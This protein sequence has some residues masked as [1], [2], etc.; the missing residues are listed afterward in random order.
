MTTTDRSSLWMWYL[1]PALTMSLGWG[2]RG[3]IGGG[4]L[5]AM[6]PGAMIGLALCY[7]LGR[8]RDAAFIA[9]FAAVGVGFGG[10]ET[11]GQTVGL[12]L[13]SETFVWAITGF[14]LKGAIWGFLG[15]AVLGIAFTIDRYARRDVVAGFACMIA[16]TFAGWKLINE[17]KLIYFSNRLDRPRAEIWAG[18]LLGALLLLLWMGWR[19]GARL[20][21]RFALWG[22]LGGGVGF[23][24]GAALQVWGRWNGLPM[25]VGWWKIMEFTFGALLGLAYGHCASVHRGELAA[26]SLPERRPAVPASLAAAIVA[27]A[28]ALVLSQGLKVRFPQTIAG[29]LLLSAAL[30]WDV[31]ARHIAVTVTYCAYAIDLQRNRL[32]YPPALMWVFIVITTIAVAVFMTRSPRVRSAFLLLT[33]SAVAMALLKTFLPPWGRGEAVGTQCA[34]VALALAVIA[35]LLRFDGSRRQTGVAVGTGSFERAR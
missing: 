6:I 24:S 18:L 23:A 31:L 14:A 22:A 19:G 3:F 17:P 7:L 11:Y 28:I 9:A 8:E 12:S 4:F 15:G 25:P 21:W 2:L 16:G 20:P 10:Q 33:V 34:F 13:I 1:F 27:L 26:N 32:D 5:G 30:Y 35:L 29:A